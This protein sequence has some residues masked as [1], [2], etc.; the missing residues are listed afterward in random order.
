MQAMAY[1]KRPLEQA[2]AGAIGMHSATRVATSINEL[3]MGLY[4]NPSTGPTRISVNLPSSGQLNMSIYSASG[5]IVYAEWGKTY[6]QGTQEIYWDGK[7]NS[8]E[9]VKAGYYI[10]KVT[11][12][13]LNSVD[14][15]ILMK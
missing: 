12:G 7:S 15:L 13:S 1:P 6:A 14:K 5:Q 11:A 4:P 3:G 2:V 8:G 9:D 10:V